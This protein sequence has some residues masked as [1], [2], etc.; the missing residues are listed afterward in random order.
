MCS[1]E[2]VAMPLMCPGCTRFIPDSAVECPYPDCG[3]DIFA[4]DDDDD[5]DSGIDILTSGEDDEP[6]EYE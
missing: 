2:V 3:I 1:W 4:A 5:D 6:E